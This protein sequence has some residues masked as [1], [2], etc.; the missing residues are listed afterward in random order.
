MSETLPDIVGL[1]IVGAV[2]NGEGDMNSKI[3]FTITAV[4]ATLYGIAFLLFPGPSLALYGVTGQ[5]SANL[6]IQFFGSALISLAVISAFARNF[7]DWE[8]VR[9]V[10][11]GLMIGDVA[12]LGVN[13]IGRGQG[14]LNSLAWS[15]TVIYVLL[16][17]GAIYCLRNLPKPT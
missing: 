17:I 6:N 11:Y 16:I 3:Y 13:S 4:L 12:G 8:A 7:Q 5:P 1:S 2:G 14:L 9:G 15:S 10:L